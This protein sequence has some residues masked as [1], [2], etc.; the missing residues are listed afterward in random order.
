VLAVQAKDN[1][2]DVGWFNDLADAEQ[3]R[4]VEELNRYELVVR[5]AVRRDGGQ[6]AFATSVM[7]EVLVVQHG[8]DADVPPAVSVTREG[9]GSRR[10]RKSG[11]G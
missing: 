9:G 3:D 7:P 10:R 1:P 5:D 6:W 4:V 8:A 2:R 11:C